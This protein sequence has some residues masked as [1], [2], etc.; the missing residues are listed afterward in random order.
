MSRSPGRARINVKT[1]AQ[2]GLGCLSRTCGSYPVLFVRTG[3]MGAASSRPSL[4]PLLAEGELSG[5]TRA[6]DASRGGWCSGC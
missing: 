2:G 4:R 3:A 6:R 5:M 1:V